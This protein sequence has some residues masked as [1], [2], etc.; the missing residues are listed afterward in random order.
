MILFRLDGP[1]T[2]YN[3]RNFTVTSTQ[4]CAHYYSTAVLSFYNSQF[5]YTFQKL[6]QL[7]T[8]RQQHKGDMQNN[9]MPPLQPRGLLLEAVI[10]GQL[11]HLQFTTLSEPK[12][13]TMGVALID[14][15]GAIHQKLGRHLVLSPVGGAQQHRVVRLL[16]RVELLLG[17]LGPALDAVTFVQIGAE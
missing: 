17:A 9:S 13:N 3:S 8:S 2:V 10:N 12:Q 6:R 1:D 14:L 4:I 16:H 11:S 5:V 15:D 7:M